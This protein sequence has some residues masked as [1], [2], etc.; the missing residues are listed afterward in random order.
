MF[1]KFL[2]LLWQNCHVLG[3]PFN[4]VHGQILKNIIL[5]SGHTVKERERGRGGGRFDAMQRHFRDASQTFS[6]DKARGNALSR[7]GK[8]RLQILVMLRKT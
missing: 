1:G 2:N 3:Q 4:A 5:S 6:R 7:N 8:A